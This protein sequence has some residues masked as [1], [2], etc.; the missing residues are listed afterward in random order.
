MSNSS[1]SLTDGTVQ[2]IVLLFMTA[3]TFIFFARFLLLFLPVN[4]LGKMSPFFDWLS[5]FLPSFIMLIYYLF[6]SVVIFCGCAYALTRLYYL[7]AKKILKR[8]APAFATFAALTLLLGILLWPLP[9]DTHESFI[10]TPNK[11]CECLGWTFEF[12]PPFIMD[13]TSTD[14]CMGWEIPLGQSP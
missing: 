8:S 9:C 3:A 10:D 12:Y 2:R 5:W 6:L 13:G 7:I 14:Y 4:V 11:H 1:H